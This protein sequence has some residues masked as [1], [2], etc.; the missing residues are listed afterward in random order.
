MV[1]DPNLVPNG[2]VAIDMCVRLSQFFVMIVN[3]IMTNG[4]IFRVSNEN[5]LSE[6]INENARRLI[7]VMFSQQKCPPCD[8]IKPKFKSLA[9]LNRDCLF[10]YVDLTDFKVSKQ[11]FVNLPQRTPTF[12]LFINGHIMGTVEGA[13]EKLLVEAVHIFKN[14]L[15]SRPTQ[16]PRSFMEPVAIP[17]SSTPPSEQSIESSTI[18]PDPVQ[19]PL[20]PATAPSPSPAP[21]A[22]DENVVHK[23][24]LLKELYEISSRFGIKLSKPFDLNSD[25]AEI[26]AEYKHHINALIQAG[27]LI[28]ES[29]VTTAPLASAPPNTPPVDP[30]QRKRDQLRKIQELIKLNQMLQVQQVKK[31]NELHQLQKIK[32]QHERNAMDSKYNNK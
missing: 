14:K 25:E 8:I 24:E 1:V 6:I 10:V 22:A 29:T 16:T 28:P 5:D 20:I 3:I 15:A 9:N 11:R 13:D 4:N 2:V 31:L 27:I 7:V 17:K 32:E 18:E 23:L 21:M 19:E 26:I 30:L 12:A